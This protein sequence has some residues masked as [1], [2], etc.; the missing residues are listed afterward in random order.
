MSSASGAAT[1][2]SELDKTGL[3]LRDVDEM[4]QFSPRIDEI[5]RAVTRQHVERHFSVR[6]MTE[7]YI[8]IY[9]Q[10]IRAHKEASRQPI[11]SVIRRKQLVNPDS[12]RVKTPLPDEAAHTV[13]RATNHNLKEKAGN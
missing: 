10:L 4:V 7:K 11:P 12:P 9:R 2:L 1:E 5:G 3:V 8:K 6:V 13:A